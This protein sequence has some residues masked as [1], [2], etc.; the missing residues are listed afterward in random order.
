MVTWSVTLCNDWGYK[1]WWKLIIS[2]N[3]CIFVIITWYRSN[4]MVKQFFNI[5]QANEQTANDSLSRLHCTSKCSG[6]SR[7]GV[8]GIIFLWTTSISE[9]FLPRFNSF[10]FLFDTM[11]RE[12]MEWLKLCETIWNI[13]SRK[14]IQIMKPLI[15]IH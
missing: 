6:I 11:Y 15:L 14:M 8:F 4:T 5:G 1:L 10:Y 3:Q 12:P 9:N 2:M 7:N 13:G